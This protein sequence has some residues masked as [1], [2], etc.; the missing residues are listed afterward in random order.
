M[1]KLSLLIAA[2]S[3]FG[4]L[5]LSNNSPKTVKAEDETQLLRPD[6]VWTQA[7]PRFDDGQFVYPWEYLGNLHNYP[8]TESYTNEFADLEIKFYPS[9]ETFDSTKNYA[10][11][12]HSTWATISADSIIAKFK[13]NNYDETIEVKPA[14]RYIAKEGKGYSDSD[15]YLPEISHKYSFEYMDPSK[16]NIF[17]FNDATN[18]GWG[19]GAETQLQ[20]D[21][22]SEIYS[23]KYTFKTGGLT[24]YAM[25]S[26]Y[27]DPATKFDRS[28]RKEFSA[29]NIEKAGEYKIQLSFRKFDGFS[30]L[31]NEDSSLNAFYKLDYVSKLET[32]SV[33]ENILR[34]KEVYSTENPTNRNAYTDGETGSGY[35]IQN[36]R[37]EKTF[38][39]WDLGSI[40]ALDNIR[41]YWEASCPIK[42][43]VFVATEELTDL[44]SFEYITEESENWSKFKLIEEVNCEQSTHDD[45]I[46]PEDG[47]PFSARY[48]LL[49]TVEASSNATRYG[50]RLHEIEA[51]TT[52]ETYFYGAQVGTSDNG[53]AIRFIGI[54]KVEDIESFNNKISFELSYSNGSD[55][56][57]PREVEINNFFKTLK[58]S[59]TGV[60]SASLTAPE[61]YYFFSFTLTGV[62][63]GTYTITLKVNGSIYQIVSYNYADEILVRL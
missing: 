42:Y 12:V 29:I 4:V 61:N 19:F 7:T 2:V 30:A 11:I 53:N 17:M 35:Q 45:F 36:T 14:L 25:D 48:I 18:L 34:N 32:N 63:E 33:G 15:Y 1:K 26:S 28:T 20:L 40:Y 52:T 16:W 39:I 24:F 46:V 9:N 62:Q 43:N 23:L 54:T 51:Y 5:T 44:D 21:P 13:E 41:T 58:T 56:F 59:L 22:E 57:G 27:E 8:G 6:E 47:H 50:Y 60:S 37:V 10:T 49:Q 38:Y 55:N 3:T 31:K